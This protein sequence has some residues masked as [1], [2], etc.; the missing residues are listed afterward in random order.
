VYAAGFVTASNRFRWTNTGLTRGQTYGYRVKA[1]DAVGNET[2]WSAVT[3]ATAAP[4]K[5]A[6]ASYVYDGTGQ[7]AGPSASNANFLDPG[8]VE[9]TDGVV[10]ATTAFNQ[11]PWV[12][13]QDDL[14][15]DGTS[16]PQVTFDLGGDRYVESIDVTY[17]H[18]TSQAGGSITAPESVLVST[19]SDNVTYSVPVTF[20]AEFDS[21]SGDA[22]RVGTLDVT[23]LPEARYYRLDFRNTSVWTFLAEVSF[24]NAPP[25]SPPGMLI[26]VR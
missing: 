23:G 12:G 19:S 22:I 7:G 21:S 1:R 17:L 26:L 6:V 14:P 3:N 4:A 15:D 9:L 24:W 8:N 13:C 10:P 20:S 25:P 5:I 16:H 18:S 11:A 2:E